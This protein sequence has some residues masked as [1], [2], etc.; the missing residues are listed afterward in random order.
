[1]R[2]RCCSTRK[3]EATTYLVDSI[4][5]GPLD[6]VKALLHLVQLILNGGHLNICD[7]LNRKRN[8]R[9]VS[10]KT[11]RVERTGEDRPFSL[12]CF[13]RFLFSNSRPS[14]PKFMTQGDRT[15]GEERCWAG[16]GVVE[17]M[18]TKFAFAKAIAS[19]GVY[20]FYLGYFQ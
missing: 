13:L 12:S 20:S 5:F 4:L 16:R 9:R 2:C 14:L 11:H 19:R 6:L 17:V 10:V 7:T 3:D 1:M 18:G 8:I 15:D